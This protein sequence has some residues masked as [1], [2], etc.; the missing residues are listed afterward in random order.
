[1][2]EIF[3]TFFTKKH[4]RRSD[5][6]TKIEFEIETTGEEYRYIRELVKKY[7]KAIRG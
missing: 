4:S 5:K 3:L 1:M 2:E 6:I 7:V